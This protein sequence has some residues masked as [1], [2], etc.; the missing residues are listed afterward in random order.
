MNRRRILVLAA[1]IAGVAVAYDL[2][3][4]WHADIRRFDPDETARLESVMWR[5]YYD[6][7]PLS[8]FLELGELLRTEF[9]LPPCRSLWVAYQASRAAFVFKEG[10]RRTDYER[11]LPHLESYFGAIEKVGSLGMDPKHVARV[12]LEWWIVHRERKNHPPGDLDR[13]VAD[14]A[15]ALYRV[16]VERVLTHGRLRS[17]AMVLRDERAEAGALNEED[18]RQIEDL[19][20][21]SYRSLA[22]TLSKLE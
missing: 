4:P 3:G 14:A 17:E 7:K 2:F 10:T 6:K 20:R 12:E 19:L 1:A 13:A 22:E 11:A 18:W 15:G 16:P 21:G 8:L 5:S 9:R